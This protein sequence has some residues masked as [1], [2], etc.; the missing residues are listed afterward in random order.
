MCTC[1][2]MKTI[3]NKSF[4]GRNMDFSHD[5][6]PHF[7][8]APRQYIWKSAADMKRIT[9]KY[10]FIGIG[11]QLDGLLAFFDGVNET[12]FAAAALYFSGYAKYDS[13]YHNTKKIQLAAFDFLKY[14]LGGCAT[15][16]DVKQAV[17]EVS[18]IGIADPVTK[19]AAPLHWIA[20]DKGGRCVV[21]E[22][23]EK[24]FAVFQNQ[25]GVL[26]NAPDF[27]WHM[28]NLNNYCN[29]TST[30]RED[31]QWGKLKLSPPSQAGGTLGLPG[32]FAS[33]E[34][35]VRTAFIKTHASTPLDD[36]SA[37]G[38]CFQ[39]LK[40]VSIPKGVVITG[41]NTSDYTLY[42]AFVNQE[43]GEYFVNTHTNQQI[44]KASINEGKY[45]QSGQEL[46]DLGSIFKPVEFLPFCH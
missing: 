42:T 25:I 13:L 1:I 8:V 10:K 2:T 46:L 15:V 30:Q 17:K 14:L 3:E 12:G 22:K 5:I 34:R 11:Q 31:V 40:S 9:T 19:T 18:L 7:F 28:A 27:P 20:T 41:R 45:E 36:D 24:G 38:L 6:D 39:C 35:F 29:I 32:G 21:I 33:P 4:F 43:K 23:T 16:F 37:V 26:A 44:Y